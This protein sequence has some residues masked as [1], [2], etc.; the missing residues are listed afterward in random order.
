MRVLLV[1]DEHKISAYVKRGLEESGYAVDAVYTGRE[2]LDWAESAPYD[3]IVLDIMLPELD[4]L[5]VCS[6]LRQRGERTPVL[7]LTARDAGG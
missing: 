6:E 2:A 7:M 1:E 5:T 3:L 4:G